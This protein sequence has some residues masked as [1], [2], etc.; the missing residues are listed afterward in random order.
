MRNANKSSAKAR[1]LELELERFRA[2]ERFNPDSWIIP[3]CARNLA[4]PLE[5][6]ATIRR[7]LATLRRVLENP[8]LPIRGAVLDFGRS[9]GPAGK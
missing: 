5:A 8:P 6:P 3:A 2:V 4:L 7:E 1:E 9:R